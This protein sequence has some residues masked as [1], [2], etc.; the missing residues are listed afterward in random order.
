MRRPSPRRVPTLIG[1]GIVA[2]ALVSC[3]PGSGS[4]GGP[5]SGLPETVPAATVD[6]QPT[7]D[8]GGVALG[9]QI[10]LQNCASCHG[11][12]TQGA[13]NWIQPDT[14]GNLPPPPHDDTGHTW[15]HS[16]AELAEIIR[17]G[18]RDVFNKTPELTMPPFKDRLN[19]EEIAAVITYF[20]SLWTVEHRRYQE[21][22]NQR[23]AM[24]MATPGATAERP[25]D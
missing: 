6:P 16:D 4:S 1:V 10:Y 8:P 19:N 11:A 24:P 15:R 25:S 17:N 5:G 13:A 14:R 22:Q 18:M 7:L 3:G 2:V 20:K 23:P 9:R 12:N 21:E